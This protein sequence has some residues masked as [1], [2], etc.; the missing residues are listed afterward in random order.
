M[1]NMSSELSEREVEILRLLATGASNKEIGA[2]LNISAN[3]VKVHVR[4]IFA[5]IDAA[6]R[7]EAVMAAVRMGLVQNPAPE[8]TVEAGQDEFIQEESIPAVASETAPVP[9]PVPQVA[10]RKPIAI[11]A[12]ILATLVVVFVAVRLS[13]TPQAPSLSP[14]TPE[15][16]LRWKDYPNLPEPRWA[17]A[18][19]AYEGSIFLIG[20]ETANGATAEVARF[21]P[22]QNAWQD[23]QAKPT[24]VFDVSA[25]VLEGEVY[26]PGGRLDERQVTDHLEIYNPRTDDWRAGPD[27]P[28]PLSAYAMVVFEGQLYLFGGWNGEQV[29]DSVLRYNPGLKA[30]TEID[31]LPSARMNSGAAVIGRKI[32]VLGGFNGKQALP[33]NLVYLPD[34][35]STGSAWG[36]AQPMPVARYGMGVTAIAEIVEVVGGT[37]PQDGEIL[38]LSY[39]PINDTWQEFGNLD[40][41][42]PVQPGIVSLGN[43]IHI[44]G[45]KVAGAPSDQHKA[46]QAIYSLSL[47]IIR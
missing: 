12:V 35:I 29:V 31:H 41:K 17:M 38:S 33:D 9:A 40:D 15:D 25:A 14:V 22:E 30:W 26:V 18:A 8:Q 47:P 4:N 28:T 43:L 44:L 45:G 34:L 32:Y 2:A 42:T 13:L 1:G 11:A 10:W 37:Q 23:A 3:T 46:Y 5:K 21:I 39:F 6:S 19:A 20:G 7:T 24:P 16:A 36:K 27:L